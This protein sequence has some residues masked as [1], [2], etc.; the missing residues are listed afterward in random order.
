MSTG[1]GQITDALLA[2]LAEKKVLYA[3]LKA[4]QG[5]QLAF[6]EDLKNKV[7]IVTQDALE[8]SASSA[9]N[10]RGLSDAKSIGQVIEEVEGKLEA[11]EG[12]IQEIQE[13][14]EEFEELL[15][16]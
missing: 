14:I 2:K 1:G 15:K 10:A 8:S 9:R 3:R 5:E 16:G 7:D 11:L 12:R 6:I 13:E 4:D